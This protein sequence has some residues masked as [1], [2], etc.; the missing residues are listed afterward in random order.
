MTRTQV[1]Q[2]SN[3]TTVADVLS[4]HLVS[5][6][7]REE[8]AYMLSLVT[9]TSPFWES[10]RTFNQTSVNCLTTKQ[11]E[12]LTNELNAKKVD[13]RNLLKE[14][15]T[16]L[17]NERAEQ[18]LNELNQAR[19]ELE[20]ENEALESNQLQFVEFEPN[21]YRTVRV[22]KFG[23]SIAKRESYIQKGKEKYVWSFDNSPVEPE[24]K[25]KFEALYLQLA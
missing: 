17:L 11:Y 7:T 18:F 4:N 19:F 21:Q 3:V 23:A 1:N 10:L 13:Y 14:F 12:C 15:R 16:S 6:T 24:V 8:M 5:V 2:L 25:Q 22:F 20:Q 9:S